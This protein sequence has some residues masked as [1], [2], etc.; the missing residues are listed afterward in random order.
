MNYAYYPTN[1]VQT[2][3]DAAGLAQADYIYLNGR[4]VAV[5]NGSTLYYLHDDRLGTP[6]LATD[7]SQNTQWQASYEPFG[8]TSSVSGTITQNL[9]FPGQYFDVESGWNHNGFRDYIPDLGR[10]A[11]PDPL[12]MEGSAGYY[13]PAIGKFIY[14]IPLQPSEGTDFYDYTGNNPTNAIDP[15]G[16]RWIV[17]TIWN[18]QGNSV[19]HAAA[20]ELNGSTILSEF[21]Q[22]HCSKAPLLPPQNWSQSLQREGR[23]PN[24]VFKV[25]IPNDAGFDKAVDQQRNMPTWD[26]NP[27]NTNQTNCVAALSR[28]MNA[29][30]V[31]A[32]SDLW[33]GNFGD[34]LSNQ[35]SYT[36]L[37]NDFGEDYPYPV[38]TLS[39][40]P[41]N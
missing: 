27:N 9:R 4:P 34:W 36:Q 15:S 19:G 3:T 12:A 11:E 20:F 30:G 35:A 28:A 5:L 18:R 8:Q 41:W 33:P 13:S 39:G 1:N 6:E 32:P 40:V 21:P 29:G 25:W 10:Y 22:C 16:L 26:W 31:P 24:R 7:S 23:Q 17:V 2:I 37:S 38:Q 14:Q